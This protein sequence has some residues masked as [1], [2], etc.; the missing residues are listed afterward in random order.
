MDAGGK[1]TKGLEVEPSNIGI[2]AGNRPGLCEL[3]RV[4]PGGLCKPGVLALASV[5]V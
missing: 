2:E 4:T 1:T 5:I 3:T